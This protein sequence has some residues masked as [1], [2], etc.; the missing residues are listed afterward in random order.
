MATV[1]KEKA[2][3]TIKITMQELVLQ[4]VDRSRAD[5][6]KWWYSLQNA[7][8]VTN[9]N[10][11]RLYDLAE[12]AIID[13]H[14]SGVM[15]KRITSVLNKNLHY[16]IKG[17]R[18]DEM[19]EV[20]NLAKFRLMMRRLW[21]K[22]AWGLTGLEFIPGKELDFTLI[23]RKH[24]KPE[25]KIISIE[26]NGWE[27]F[28]YEGM[29]NIL[30]VED[31]ERFG[32]LN[33]SIPLV[34]LK[35]GSLS[36]LAQYIE[37]YGQPIR[38]G[39]YPGD[40]PDAKATLKQALKEA[41]ASYSIVLPEGTT[42]EI[43][44]D[45]VTNGTGQVHQVL[46]DQIN[47]ELSILWLGNVETTSNNNG[48]SNAKAVEQ[49]KQQD[50]IIRSDLKDMADMLSTDA[51]K[52][53][54]KSY[55]YP[56]SPGD[57][58]RFIYEAEIDLKELSAKKDVWLAVSGKVPIGDD[59]W[60]N[61]FDIP[62]PKDYEKLKAAMEEEKMMK[63]QPPAPGQPAPAKEK[64]KKEPKPLADLNGWEKFMLKMSD[65]FDLGHKA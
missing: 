57:G 31:V 17:K 15:E 61:T 58:G 35:T 33:K 47:N 39:T 14:L 27:G 10:R 1:K 28:E 44:G 65:F 43:I 19:D 63:L 29:W 5:L 21:E 52:L 7:E 64:K 13:A 37:I 50:E 20:I 22:K 18:V 62:K 36:D 16:E 51:L 11:S 32:L 41:G 24:I 49:G 8:Q 30:I 23:P 2:K 53:I 40:D 9:P 60:Y 38:K 3:E 34:L 12:R 46:F 55:G 45:H 48:G 6:K 56:C 42:V 54:L 59:D 4:S 25:A 26:Q